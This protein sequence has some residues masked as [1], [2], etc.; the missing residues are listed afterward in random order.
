VNDERPSSSE[1]SNGDGSPRDQ[2]KFFVGP[3]SVGKPP[4]ARLGNGSSEVKAEVPNPVA[5]VVAPAAPAPAP[6]SAPAE[7]PPAASV[8]APPRVYVPAPGAPPP[9]RSMLLPEGRSTG[10]GGAGSKP[11][12]ISPRKDR[13]K[14]PRRTRRRILQAVAIILLI[15]LLAIGA[16]LIWAQQKFSEIE[17]V[18]VADVLDT[19]GEG[20]NILMVGS[21]A[22]ADRAGQRSDTIMLLRFE[23]DRSLVMSIPRDLYVTIV[24]GGNEQRINAAYNEGPSSLIQTVQSNLDLPI[25]RYMEVDFVTFAGLVDAVGGVTIDFPHPVFDEKAGLNIQQTGPVLLDGAQA[26]AYVRSRQYT[27]IIDGRQVSDPR[28][29]LGRVLRQQQFMRVLFGKI[30]ES[31]NPFD[32]AR[33]ATSVGEGLRIDDAMTLFDAIR[34]ALRLRGLDPESVELPTEPFTAPGGAFV[35]G[36]N[37]DTAE[38]ALEQFR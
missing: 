35:L 10:G 8:D 5:V 9:R 4:P 27:E 25:H 18:A 36:L 14:K 17:K 32:L 2:R 19:G 31:R 29:D 13:P 37:E 11:P 22:G 33:V 38:A 15:P 28:G 1:R 23:G 20:L 16:G 12:T 30:G 7:D 34:V 6:A 21:D 3:E 26:L 24:P